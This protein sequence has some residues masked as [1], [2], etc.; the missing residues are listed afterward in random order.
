M[1]TCGAWGGVGGPLATTGGAGGTGRGFRWEVGVDMV[2]QTSMVVL[3]R[4]RG[5]LSEDIRTRWC[6][7]CD[8]CGAHW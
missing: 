7:C 8:R 1:R 6:K 4:C 2:V 3:L 5:R